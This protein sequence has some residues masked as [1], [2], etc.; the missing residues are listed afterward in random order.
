V[1]E[2][3]IRNHIEELGAIPGGRPRG[4]NESIQLQCL[5]LLLR[6][7]ARGKDIDDDKQE[8]SS[9]GE[10]SELHQWLAIESGDMF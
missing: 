3:V 1:P 9:Y 5:L 4:W 10:A 2:F 8:H 6:G 7:S